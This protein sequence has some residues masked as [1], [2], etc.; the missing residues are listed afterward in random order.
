A[1][2]TLAA[3]VPAGRAAAAGDAAAA[4]VPP[5][6]PATTPLVAAAADL[7]FALPEIAAGFARETGQQ[8]RLVFGS[9]GNFRRQIEEGAPFEVFLSADQS[10]VDAIAREGRTADAGVVYAVGRLALIVPPGSPIALDPQLR[11]VARALADG[12]LRRFAIANPEH[13]PYGRAARQALEHAGLWPAIQPKLV[14]GENISQTAQFAV[15][16][17]AQGGIV[18]YS[19]LRSKAM[20]GRGDFVVL[21]ASLYDPL[22]Q[23][24][25]LI[26]GATAPARAFYRYLQGPKARAIFDRYGFEAPGPDAAAR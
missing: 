25:V 9:S 22:V 21:P 1:L 18:A 6:S 13:A 4:A 16:G 11:G 12:S 14:L 20:A 10:Y 24:M 26:K 19:L 7:Q 17:A 2:L 15:S 5:A 3:I 23:K 8:V